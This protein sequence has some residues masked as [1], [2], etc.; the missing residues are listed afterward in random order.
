MLS[1]QQGNEIARL[2]AQ[3]FNVP[4]PPEIYVTSKLPA[5]YAG[6]FYH[7]GV[8]HIKI[9]PEYFREGT[10]AHEVGH[11]IFHQ[12]RPGE[13]QGQNSECELV[14]HMIEVWWLDK[15][16]KEHALLD[17]KTREP[18]GITYKLNRPITLKEAQFVA[19]KLSQNP[20]VARGID[21]IGFKDDTFY[22]IPKT[23]P[24]IDGQWQLFLGP[25]L[26]GAFSLVGIIIKWSIIG[27]IAG[28]LLAKGPFGLPVVFWIVI[29]IGGAI[30]I[31]Y[32]LIKL[33]K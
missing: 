6:A 11:Y 3:E 21:R 13:C 22:V 26:V 8:Q 15:R 9:R 7:N 16:R 1:V 10:I 4:P 5:Q 19:D 18:I 17:G 28:A 14:A 30:V 32:A 33:K 27:S 24:K 31:P 12:R 29:A 23:T 20:Q 2:V 25:A